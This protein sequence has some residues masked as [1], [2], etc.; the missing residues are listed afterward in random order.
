M[1]FQN[2][3]LSL[4]RS[5][6]VHDAAPCSREDSLYEGGRP[7]DALSCLSF[8]A[9]WLQSN[10]SILVRETQSAK[11]IDLTCFKTFPIKSATCLQVGPMSLDWQEDPL[12]DP[13][14]PLMFPATNN[15]EAL[16]QFPHVSVGDRMLFKH[17]RRYYSVLQVGTDVALS[18]PEVCGV[19]FGISGVSLDLFSP[20]KGTEN[21]NSNILKNSWTTTTL[22]VSRK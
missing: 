19:L 22:F 9:L 1:V 12:A 21:S 8:S 4:T 2:I 10:Q 17:H 20:D 18:F 5:V 7:C 6:I 13:I 3:V 11:E 15:N 14:P 16:F